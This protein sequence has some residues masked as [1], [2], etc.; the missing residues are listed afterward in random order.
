MLIVKL[1]IPDVSCICD[2]VKWSKA[3]IC[4]S[5]VFQKYPAAE[6]FVFRYN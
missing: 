1:K 4:G 6:F 5:S 3:I 2:S